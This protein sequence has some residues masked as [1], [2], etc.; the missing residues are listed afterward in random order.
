MIIGILI[1]LA[2]LSIVY[3]PAL[4]VKVDHPAL[5]LLV[6]ASHLLGL[7][8]VIAGIIF[9]LGSFSFWR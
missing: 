6:G 2:V 7:G 1:Y 9:G 3:L 4:F 8:M 5:I